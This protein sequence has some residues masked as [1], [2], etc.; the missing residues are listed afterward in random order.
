MRFLLG[1]LLALSVFTSCRKETIFDDPGAL[2]EFSSDTVFF[3]TVF[4]SLGSSTERLMVFNPYGESIVIS[5][6][7]LENGENSRFRINVD[8]ISGRSFSDIIIRP[9]DS[10]FIFLEVTIDPN[11]SDNPMIV[12]EYLTFETNGNTQ[13]IDLVAWG[14]DAYYYRPT[15]AVPGL[16][17]FSFLS[18]YDSFPFIG[19]EIRMKADKP[20]VILG[21]LLV[22]S[23]LTLHIEAGAQIHF[24]QFS[25]LWVSQGASL[26]VKGELDNEVVFQGSRLEDNWDDRP[27]QWDRIWINEGARSEIEY[28]IIKNGFVGIQAESWP[29]NDPL[30]YAQEPLIIKNTIIENMVG[31]GLLARD[32]KIEAENVL[33]KDCGTHALAING[34][35]DY[36]FI[37]CS[38]TNYWSGNRQDPLLFI[39][40]IFSDIRGETVNRDL[41]RA[42]FGNCV[43]YGAREEELEI[44]EPKA[45]A[46]NLAFEYSIFRTEVE[47]QNENYFTNCIFNPANASGANHPLFKNISEGDFQLL[48]NSE[49]VDAGFAYLNR[50]TLDLAGTSRD[51]KPDIGCYELED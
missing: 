19:K 31:I 32:H 50:L 42:F 48:A 35:G 12:Q 13:K 34:G 37:N 2:L 47:E 15:T 16:P 44:E 41:N 45:G 43:F 9:R 25:G 36:E 17:V 18:S 29:F 28:A 27:G 10:I 40:N 46:F 1:F 26:V 11:R 30:R 8:G 6:I 39:N 21:Y 24:F 3:D 20:H 22:D 4:T 51:A 7:A 38:F 14:Q 5:K 23:S 49:A 33:I